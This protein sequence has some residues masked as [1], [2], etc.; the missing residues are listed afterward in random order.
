MCELNTRSPLYEKGALNHLANGAANPTRIELVTSRLTVVRSE[1]TELRILAYK[2]ADLLLA[3]FA[4]A[5]SS[6]LK[7][8]LDYL[9]K[10]AYD[11]AEF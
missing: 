11:S 4:P 5:I 10:E 6:L 3:G 2:S 7:R 9:A 8:R 1:P